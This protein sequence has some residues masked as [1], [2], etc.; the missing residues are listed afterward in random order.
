MHK[1]LEEKKKRGGLLS[2]ELEADRN[3]ETGGPSSSPITPPVMAYINLL[4]LAQSRHCETTM[5][6]DVLIFPYSLMRMP[7]TAKAGAF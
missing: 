3:R 5:K 7:P 2:P 1:E 6:F 4:V